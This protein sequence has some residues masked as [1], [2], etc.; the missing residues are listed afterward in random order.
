MVEYA[1]IQGVNCEEAHAEQLA[2]FLR[3]V[4]ARG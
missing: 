4:E 1:C 3:P 2:P